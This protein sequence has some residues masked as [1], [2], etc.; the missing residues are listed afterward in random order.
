VRFGQGVGGRVL[1]KD[2]DLGAVT[3]YLEFVACYDELVHLGKA[4]VDRAGHNVG[5]VHDVALVVGDP[6]YNNVYV[7]DY[8]A[9]LFEG[10]EAEVYG[11]LCQRANSK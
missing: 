3:G 1:K 5:K 7:V 6:V 2:A 4:F 8:V 10:L 9:E 11:V